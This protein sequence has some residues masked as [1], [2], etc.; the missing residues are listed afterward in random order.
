MYGLST[1][2]AAA[3][4]STDRG[5]SFVFCGDSQLTV[6]HVNCLVCWCGNGPGSDPLLDIHR[7]Q[8][9]TACTYIVPLQVVQIMYY[10]GSCQ[11]GGGTVPAL[12]TAG[13]VC[14]GTVRARRQVAWL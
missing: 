9:G 1:A 7:C 12:G 5:Q 11:P 13:L 3:T 10:S 4:P 2:A 8:Y 6:W 14:V